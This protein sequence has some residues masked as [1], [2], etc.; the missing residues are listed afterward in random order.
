GLLVAREVEVV[1]V[2]RVGGLV[3]RNA[4]AELCPLLLEP[5]NHGGALLA[6]AP[7]GRVVDSVAH[8]LYEVVI[9]VVWAVVVAGL[10][11]LRCAAARVDDAARE[12]AGTAAVGAVEH[13]HA[14]APVGRLDCGCG[15]CIA[16]ADDDHIELFS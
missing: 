8:L 9:E 16:V 10:A 2:G 14:S 15:A 4:R 11:L 1:P 5:R 12:R 3:G 6:E 13:E 7:E